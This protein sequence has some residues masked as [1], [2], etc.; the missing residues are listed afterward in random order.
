MAIARATC[1]S[2]LLSVS[3]AGCI[4]SPDENEARGRATAKARAGTE[5]DAGAGTEPDAS[6]GT[7]SDAAVPDA[8]SSLGAED[9]GTWTGTG[10]A[11]DASADPFAA[12]KG[13]SG[14][15]PG[16]G[17]Y[18]LRGYC[19]LIPCTSPDSKA[20]KDVGGT[21]REEDFGGMLLLSVCEVRR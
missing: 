9:A 16:V 14:Y 6:D 8:G 2:A 1:L 20:C 13:E 18:C 21:C 11:C 7:S 5:P 19:A 17:A 4:A 15:L 12:C 3:V 10:L